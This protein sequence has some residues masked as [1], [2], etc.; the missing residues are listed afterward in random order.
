MLTTRRGFLQQMTWFTAVAA[1]GGTRAG[2]APTAG[3]SG[4][5]L[6]T[7][8]LARYVDPLPIPALAKPTGLRPS[9]VDPALHVP[10]YRLAMRQFQAKVHR[11]VATTTFWGYDG[12]CPG[13]T[14]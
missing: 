12:S 4:P 5:L 9:P 14:F 3:A 1:T 6:D 8:A 13:P 7:S 10:Y 2:H 11:D